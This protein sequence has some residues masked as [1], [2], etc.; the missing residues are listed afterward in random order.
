TDNR[1]YQVGDI[2]LLESMGSTAGYL[3]VLVLALYINSDQV[4][5]LYSHPRILWRICPLLLYWV[6][7]IWVWGRRGSIAEDPLLFALKDRMSWVVLVA[8][9]VLAILSM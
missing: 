5:G 8:I 2:P 7:R 1:G 9:A 6:S 3:A 4:V